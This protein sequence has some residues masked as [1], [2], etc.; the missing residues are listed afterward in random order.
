MQ[1]K[2]KRCTQKKWLDSV[3]ILDAIYQNKSNINS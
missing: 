2:Y 1:K 3:E